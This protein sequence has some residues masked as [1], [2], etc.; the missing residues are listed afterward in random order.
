MARQKPIPIDRYTLPQAYHRWLYQDYVAYWHDQT[1]ETQQLW[2][3]NARR[4]HMT[5]FAYW[6]KYHLAN[7]PDIA[8]GYHLDERTGITAIDFSKNKNTGT[9][10]GPLHV[11]GYIDYAL[12]F[13]GI[14]DY[15]DL[16]NDPSIRLTDNFTVI[17]WVASTE[18]DTYQG[19]LT[20]L[21][22]AL[23]KGWNLVKADTNR[24]MMQARDGTN[25]D[26][27]WSDIT[28]TDENPHHL[29]TIVKAGIRYLYVDGKIQIKTSTLAIAP[30]TGKLFLGRW[31]SDINKWNLK[32]MEDE[33]LIC[34]RPLTAQDIKRHCERGYPA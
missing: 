23:F 34:N 1:A 33:V 28:Y 21:D 10:H 8:A 31:Y 2:E 15:V 14:D 20:H 16:G 29:A 32:G 12:L 26:N 18:N 9:L 7:L 25:W 6:M 19:L 11:P 24:F 27:I 13:D 17:A 4:H 3:T 5:G 22:N 30:H